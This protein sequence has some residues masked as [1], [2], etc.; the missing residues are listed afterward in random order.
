MPFTAP[1]LHSAGTLFSSVIRFEPQTGSGTAGGF[2]LYRSTINVILDKENLFG[3]PYRPSGTSYDL[4]PVLDDSLTYRITLIQNSVF[5]T[6][7]LNSHVR[8]VDF[9]NGNV[10]NTAPTIMQVFDQANG[11]T[12]SPSPVDHT[13]DLIDLTYG[14]NLACQFYTGSGG[15]RSGGGF[16]EIGVNVV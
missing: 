3:T 15:T 12:L 14:D 10:N 8:L 1:L 7:P 9:D 6:T 16:F 4:L 11:G 13:M 5:Y 2:F